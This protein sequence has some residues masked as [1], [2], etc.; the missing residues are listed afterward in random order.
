MI[1][2]CSDVTFICQILEEDVAVAR[3]AFVGA[4][5]GIAAWTSDMMGALLLIG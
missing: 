2:W 5:T 1:G 4:T 3:E